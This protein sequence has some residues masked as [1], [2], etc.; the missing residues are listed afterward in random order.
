MYKFVRAGYL[1]FVLGFVS[2]DFE[3]GTDVS[4][5]ESTVSTYGA[6][7]IFNTVGRPIMDC[8]KSVHLFLRA[9]V[10]RTKTPKNWCKDFLICH[11]PI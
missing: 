8:T 10:S 7:F 6:N 3:V 5:E 2:R 9:L 1:I 11:D 4:C